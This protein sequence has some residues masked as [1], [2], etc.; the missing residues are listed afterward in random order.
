MDYLKERENKRVLETSDAFCVYQ[1][2]EEFIYIVDIYVRPEKR[3][4][5]IASELADQVCEIA[6]KKGF[7]FIVGSV[8]VS[9][10][11][12]TESLKVL[13]AYGMRVDSILNNVIY[14]KKD[15]GG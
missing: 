10:L 9:A 2:Y 1:E 13:L 5:G 15:I 6:K 14:F 4:S 12:A 7:K 11:G 3:K 8:D